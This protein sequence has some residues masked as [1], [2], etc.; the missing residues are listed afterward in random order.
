MEMSKKTKN[1]V[2]LTGSPRKGGNTD[3]LADAF[4]RG[5]QAA[6]HRVVR[7]SAQEAKAGGCMACDY[8]IKHEG[9][10]VQQDGMQ[11][12]YDALKEADALVLASPV[13]YFGL[14]AQLKAMVDRFYASNGGKPYPIAEAALLLALEGDVEHDA[15]S[16]VAAYHSIIGFLKWQDRGVVAAG[17]VMEK[18]AIAGH[19]ALAQAESLGRTF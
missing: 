18:G 9:N 17:G 12:V 10:C 15:A 1:I 2:L 8:C 16:T 7:F 3:E 6:G 13:Y 11:P 5:A 19:P 4:V 14:S